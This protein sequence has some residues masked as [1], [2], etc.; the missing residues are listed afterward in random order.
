MILSKKNKNNAPATTPIEA[1]TAFIMPSSSLMEMAGRIKLKMLAA[2]MTPPVKPNIPS[3]KT[4]FMVL[5]KNTID[6]PRAV[7]AQVKI[8]AK[9]A[10]LMGEIDEK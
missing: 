9:S 5:K 2:I 8:V 6:A 1:G 10:A 4:R 7:I 3:R